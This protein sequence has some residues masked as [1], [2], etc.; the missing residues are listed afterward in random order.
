MPS[1]SLNS[2]NDTKRCAGTCA[3]SP[4]PCSTCLLV[5]NTKASPLRKVIPFRLPTPPVDPLE[6]VA[7]PEDAALADKLQWLALNLP[8]AMRALHHVVEGMLRRHRPPEVRTR[9]TSAPPLASSRPAMTLELTDTLEY[10]AVQVY[11]PAAVI[12][13][14]D[15][16][17]NRR[18]YDVLPGDLCEKADRAIHQAKQTHRAVRYTHDHGD[19]LRWQ[20]CVIAPAPDLIVATLTPVRRRR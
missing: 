1:H 16:L 11:D 12:I 15:A 6:L 18:I 17:L 14:P 7:P 8:H 5:S 3:P 19:G 2:E 20:R 10:R 13:P 9:R 4:T